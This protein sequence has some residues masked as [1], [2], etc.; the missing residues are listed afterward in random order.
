M[1]VSII[2]SLLWIQYWGIL[3]F[4]ISQVVIKLW[5]QVVVSSAQL[6]KDTLPCLCNYWQSS[7]LCGML[8]W[9]AKFIAVHKQ[10]PEGCLQFLAALTSQHGCLLRK[11]SKGE[12]FLAKLTLQ[13]KITSL[14][15]HKHI[16]VSPMSYS[17]AKSKSL[18]LSTL[19]IWKSLKVINARS[20]ELWRKKLKSLSVKLA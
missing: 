4:R 2:S 9:E 5:Y 17:I 19:K 7:V 18:V 6:R 8:D 14:Y 3:C 15:T 10:R 1:W 20:Q 12:Y 11:T 13:S 16:H